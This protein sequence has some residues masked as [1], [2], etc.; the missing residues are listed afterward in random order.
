MV[1]KI[2]T[3][4]LVTAFLGGAWLLAGAQ[5]AKKEGKE[6]Y[7]LVGVKNCKMCH[8]KEA[9]GAQFTKWS[10][11]PHAK[12]FATLAS[13]AA[14]A[15]AKELGLGNPQEEEKCLKCHVTAFAVRGDLENQ[16]VTMEESVSCESCHGPGSGYK[17]KKV[18]EDI[19]AGTVD[20]AS[21]G[22]WKPDEKV[23]VTCHNPE[24]P[25]HKEF[26]FAEFAKKIA[27]PI[28]KAEGK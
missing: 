23:C 25:F 20:P 8:N 2:L 5:E 3:L 7:T 16:K 11:G 10:E 28:P 12:A 22:L 26:K 24:N 27:H 19:T 4:T 9:T 13:E 6:T 15:K 18:M 1:K 17:T 21:V 14:V